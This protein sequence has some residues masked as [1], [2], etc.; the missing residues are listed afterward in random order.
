MRLIMFGP[1][2]VGKGTQAKLLS[3]ELGIPHISTGDMLRSAVA[4]GTELGKR[5]KAIMESGGLVPDDIMIGIVREELTSSRALKGF[6]LDGFP[7]TLPQAEALTRLFRELD[8]NSYLVVNF[9][10]EDDAIIARLG[11]RLVCQKD[12]SIFTLGTNGITMN[13]PCPLCGGKLI[14]RE[15]DREDTVRKRLSVYHATTKPLI[16][17]Y[18]KVA[19]VIDI[20][21][22][23][24]IDEVNREI[25]RLI[26]A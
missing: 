7:R 6:I 10:V 9:E 5:A 15:D 20:N 3:Q 1:P 18:E 14:Q 11:K 4:H 17:Y 13:T 22:V 12:G 8:V 25:K 2:G 21:G 23:G 19:T 16:D 26:H 24:S